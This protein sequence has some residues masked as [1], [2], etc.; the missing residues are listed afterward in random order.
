M[1]SQ[2]YGF[3]DLITESDVPHPQFAVCWA[4]DKT[5]TIIQQHKT[6]H[7]HTVAITV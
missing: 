5:V 6:V 4:G 7:L 2:S 1:P 3:T